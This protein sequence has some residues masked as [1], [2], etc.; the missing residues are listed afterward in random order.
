[1]NE[2]ARQPDQEGSSDAPKMKSDVEVDQAR[3]GSIVAA[4]I[5]IAANMDRKVGT[6]ARVPLVVDIEP[7][8]APG[9]AAAHFGRWPKPARTNDSGR[10]R[11]GK[12]RLAHGPLLP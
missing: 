5:V 3:P 11:P 2:S 6:I 12:F 7:G 4:T 9:N 8:D 1:M 10:A